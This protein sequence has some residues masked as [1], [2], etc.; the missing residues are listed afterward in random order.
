MSENNLQVLDDDELEGI[1]GG[2]T[3][4][5]TYRDTVYT[6]QKGDTLSGIAVKFGTTV[7]QLQAWNPVI[8]NPDKIFEG[9][10]IIVKR[11]KL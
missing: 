10:K 9:Q 8:T 11:E 3:S 7:K 5:V 2:N 1:S 6:V 4:T